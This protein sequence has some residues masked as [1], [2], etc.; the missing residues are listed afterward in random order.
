MFC[1]Q[2]EQT[3][4]KPNEIGCQSVKGMCGKE[5][6]TSDLQDLLNYTLMGISMYAHRARQLGASN[7]EIDHFVSPAFFTTLTNVNFDADRFV[8]LIGEAIE[9]RAKAK[10]MYLHAC[11]D[12]NTAAETLEGPASWLPTALT[13]ESLQAQAE[14]ASITQGDT[15]AD[16]FGMQCLLIY[17]LKGLCAY[18]THALELGKESDEI[19][20]GVHK[21]LDFIASESQDLDALIEASMGI[22][23]LNLAV[24]ALLDEGNT[25][26]FG[27]P[28]PTSV[29]TTP[30]RGKA[31]LV[32]GHDLQDLY[33]LLKQ[34]E[35]KGINVYTHGEMLPANAYPKLKAFSHLIGNYGGA[36]QDQLAEFA[37]FPGAIL[38]TS[39]CLMDPHL[40]GYQ[41]RLFTA[42]PVGW[43]GVTHIKD[44]DFTPL[45]ES[46]LAQPGFKEDHIEQHVTTGFARNTVMSVADTVI[47]AVKSGDIKHFFLIGGCDGAKPGRNYFTDFAENTPDDSV[48]LTLGCGKFRFNKK[49]HGEIGGIPR[50]LDVGQCNDAYSAIQIAVA[51]A[52]AFECEVNDLPLTLIVSWFEQKA[53][54][55]LLSLL[56][57]GI[58]NIHLGP[59]L[60]AYLSPNVVNFLVEN[61]DLKPTGEAK[62]D[63]HEILKAS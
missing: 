62:E 14:I 54:A 22:G 51:L 43:S 24:M 56:A 53:A 27:H 34:T 36:W 26:S 44:R 12:T 41:D 42:G 6:E 28:E 55:V 25:S 29:R 59:T 23:H 46:A 39:N 13:R 31:I 10:A 20:A 1:I 32:S 7:H 9:I 11:E 40:R 63:I 16:I 37:K 60:P 38:M 17:G 18:Y 50:L 52:D 8:A 30:V 57:L 5:P 48:I 15:D 45:I 49:D 47:D 58:K 21:Y 33:E 35:G 61:F 19:Y 2:C 4:N 3:T